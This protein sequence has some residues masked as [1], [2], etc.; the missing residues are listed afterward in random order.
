MKFLPTM[1]EGVFEVE[2][3][4][5]H[6]ERGWLARTFSADLFRAAGLPDRFEQCS[7]SWNRRAGTLRG[8]H[9][10]AA[11]HGE[12][13]LIGCVRGRV[14]DVA[15]DLRPTS[16]SYCRWVSCELSASRH[17][18]IFIPPGCAHGF[19]TLDD[20]C[21]LSYQIDQ[22]YSAEAAR[23]VRWNDP[24]FAIAWPATPTCMSERDTRCPDFAP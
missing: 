18:A 16:P 23:T 8:L 4:P 13:K 19:L 11:P 17:N 9:Y 24:S 7:L 15:V 10:Q 5:H 2:L 6:D 14:F 3:Q 1:I 22:P 21:E 12:S 20:D